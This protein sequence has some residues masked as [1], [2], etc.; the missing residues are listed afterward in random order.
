MPLQ[1]VAAD[2]SSAPISV[3]QEY[4]PL[5]LVQ[6]ENA[7]GVTML[8]FPTFDAAMEEFYSKVGQMNRMFVQDME[9]GFYGWRDGSR[10]LGTEKL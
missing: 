7:P 5:S 8:P 2:G 4:Y 1:V 9:W 3:F 10:E 6:V